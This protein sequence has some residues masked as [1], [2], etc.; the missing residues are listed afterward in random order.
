M[1]KE[2]PLN[3][4]DTSITPSQTSP[5][6][7]R[8]YE[9]FRAFAFRIPYAAFLFWPTICF[10]YSIYC[11]Q[12]YRV[13]LARII[14]YA[15]IN[16]IVYG[17]A[18]LLAGSRERAT[19]GT[20]LFFVSRW[21]L[22]ERVLVFW[23]VH[24]EALLIPIVIFPLLRLLRI[25]R[26][27]NRVIHLTVAMLM[28][29]LHFRLGLRWVRDH[30]YYGKPFPAECPSPTIRDTSY[31]YPD[32]YCLVFDA[33]GHP[34]TLRRYLNIPLSYPNKLMQEGF[35]TASIHTPRSGT[36][37]SLY[38]F[39]SPNSS[40]WSSSAF[41]AHINQWGV[42]DIVAYTSLPLTLR[43]RGYYLTGPLPAYYA[44]QS[45]PCFSFHSYNIFDMTFPYATRWGVFAWH[46]ITLSQ[47]TN[48]PIQTNPTFYY[49]HLLT[50]HYPYVFDTSGHYHRSLR[51]DM[52]TL[53][54]SFIYTEKLL[55]RLIDDIRKSRQ[56]NPRPYAILL[57]SDH[58]PRG[59]AGAP[60]DLGRDT[61][62]LIARS[63]F[64]ALYT[65][66]ELPDS[67]RQAFLQAANHQDL[68]RIVLQIANP[69]SKQVSVPSS[70]MEGQ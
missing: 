70:P 34:D 52:T 28:I 67:I 21:I 69:V 5:L 56:G 20:V 29:L 66:W 50:S 8:F 30:Y 40:Y 54:A 61:A 48:L 51:D 17:L 43:E 58:G 6:L 36:V 32:I 27:I 47:K 31:T 13:F 9:R 3:N 62:Q 42:Y 18:Y 2:V 46:Y 60:Y 14:I 45:M 1:Q 15:L 63:A 23:R 24:P 12:P 26:R 35:A 4:P 53:R 10:Y 16:L 44:L 68:G 65:S 22:P 55:L 59:L 7:M 49:Y 41:W 39:L 19:V 33:F 38:H 57:F 64:A 25:G 11:Y 37:Y